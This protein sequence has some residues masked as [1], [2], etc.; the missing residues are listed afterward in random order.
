MVTDQILSYFNEINSSIAQT[1]DK[2]DAESFTLPNIKH[3]TP[4]R[5]QCSDH[6]LNSEVINA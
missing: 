1:D 4:E 3:G 2:N 5:K 6:N